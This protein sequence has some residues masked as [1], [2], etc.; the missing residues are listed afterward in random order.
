MK[1]KLVIELISK[2]SK[3][4]YFKKN[5]RKK[6]EKLEIKKFDP[7]IKKHCYYKQK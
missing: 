3:S 5:G 7:F 1:K 6:K 4:I 2:F